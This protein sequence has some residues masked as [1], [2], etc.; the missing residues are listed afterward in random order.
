MP[1]HWVAGKQVRHSTA[2]HGTAQYGLSIEHGDS[3][4][5]D[6]VCD[7]TPHAAP[8]STACKC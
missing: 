6:V 7:V 3:S 2:Q 5:G 8:Y 1:C 4:W